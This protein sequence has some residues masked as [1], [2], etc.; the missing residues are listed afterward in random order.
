MKKLAVTELQ[1]P[2]FKEWETDKIKDN[3]ELLK[4]QFEIR[5]SVTLKS[6]VKIIEPLILR[7]NFIY[8]LVTPH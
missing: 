1:C 2:E 3:F 5:L 7:R 4:N 8:N 6:T